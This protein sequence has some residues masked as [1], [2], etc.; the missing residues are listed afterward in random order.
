MGAK[1]SMVASQKSLRVPGVQLAPLMNR[2]I[3]SVEETDWECGR[4]SQC[5]DH[6]GEAVADRNQSIGHMALLL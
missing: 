6:S 5:L 4:S 3:A 2:H 1:S